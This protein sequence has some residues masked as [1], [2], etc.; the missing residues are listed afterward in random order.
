MSLT[1]VILAAGQG[2]RMRSSR[3]KVLHPVA[4]RPILPASEP[5]SPKL[6]A[7]IEVAYGSSA[8]Q[9]TGGDETTGFRGTG[10]E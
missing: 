4:G 8:A 10:N 6:T 5:V 7:H 2:K 9:W 3:P 1:V